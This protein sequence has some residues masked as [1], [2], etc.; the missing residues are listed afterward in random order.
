MLRYSSFA[1]VLL[2]FSILVGM[3]GYHY[4]AN[5]SWIDSFQMSCLILTGMG[6]T[7]IMPSDEA[8]VFSSFYTLYSGVTFLTISAIVLTPIIHRVLHILHVEDAN[9]K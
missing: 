6:P 1:L 2:V 5:L 8:K 3:Y 9:Q 4:W 7:D